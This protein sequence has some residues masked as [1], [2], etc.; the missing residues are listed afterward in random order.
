MS[1]LRMNVKRSLHS[2]F[3]PLFCEPVSFGLSNVKL[4]SAFSFAVLTPS[5]SSPTCF[6][7]RTPSLS[8]V[9][10]GTLASSPSVA[11]VGSAASE[12]VAAT[13]ETPPSPAMISA[14]FASDFNLFAS[15]FSN[16]A[17]CNSF[18]FRSSATKAGKVSQSHVIRKTE[19]KREKIEKK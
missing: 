14:F 17:S 10:A 16:I 13:I 18:C 1:R 15:C 6:V 8:L 4:S 7:S 19:T 11:V 3:L 9:E 12:G 2:L 5:T